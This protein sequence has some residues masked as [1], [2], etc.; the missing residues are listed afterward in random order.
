MNTEDILK[1]YKLPLRYDP[2]GQMIWDADNNY[3]ADIRGWGR[4]QYEDN[5]EAIQDGMG[6]LI[7]R[8]FNDK[9]YK[10]PNVVLVAGGNSISMVAA[11]A[12]RNAELGSV[13]VV[14]Q[15]PVEPFDVSPIVHYPE[16]IQMS[17]K[18]ARRLRRAT[19]RRKR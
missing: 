2:T 18:E 10:K 6:E 14:S 15:S 11:L 3:V 12:G 9:H 17:G 5:P 7:V 13:S 19:Q 1:H 4:L 8:A 16:P